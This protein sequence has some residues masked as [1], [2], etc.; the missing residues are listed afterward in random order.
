MSVY[1]LS[2]AWLLVLLFVK[3]DWLCIFLHHMI[4]N[5][6]VN[7]KFRRLAKNFTEW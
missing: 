5:L 6:V 3:C 4:Y 2:G 7:Q 1:L